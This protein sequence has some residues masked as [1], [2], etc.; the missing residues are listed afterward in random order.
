[1]NQVNLKI[2]NNKVNMLVSALFAEKFELNAN[3]K[4]TKEQA[5]ELSG[6]LYE[7]AEQLEQAEVVKA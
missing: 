4:L 5:L 7:M 3:V 1:M 2:E 6:Q